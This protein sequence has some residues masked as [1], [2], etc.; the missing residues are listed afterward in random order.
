MST[1]PDVP[2]PW[3]LEGE[4]W[5]ML[6][7]PL[8]TLPYAAYA[9]L[10]VPR[11]DDPTIKTNKFLGGLGTVWIVRYASSP[12]GPYDELIYVPGDFVS[13]SGAPKARITRIYVSTAV[14]TYNGRKNWNVP[15]HLARFKFTPQAGGRTLIEVFDF[16]EPEET[17]APFFAAVA[18]PQRFIPSLPFTTNWLKFGRVP[19]P[20]LPTG[21]SDHP[22]EVGTEEW[23]AF[24]QETKGWVKICW[25]EPAPV[26]EGGRIA[27]GEYAD[28]VGFPKLD[29]RSFGVQFLPGMT[30]S[31]SERFAVE[32]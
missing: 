22:E 27:P 26:R 11:G 17:A 4:C 8:Q 31:F 12:A 20:P 28:G 32:E 5:W 23:C 2:P 18:R 29:I 13:P 7:Q 10:E 30:I 15:K 1:I 19:L 6:L 21:P 9:P 3:H 16:Y 24:E 25:W 14:S